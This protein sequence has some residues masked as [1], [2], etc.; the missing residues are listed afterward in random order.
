MAK[1]NKFPLTLEMMQD[2]QDIAD[3]ERAKRFKYPKMCS[4]CGSSNLLAI[5][6]HITPIM[7]TLYQGDWIYKDGYDGDSINDW[8]NAEYHCEDC[9]EDFEPSCAIDS[10][11]DGGADA[12]DGEI[13]DDDDEIFDDDDEIFDSPMEMPVDDGADAGTN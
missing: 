1:I 2:A 4:K 8:A 5:V 11:D 13:F 6:P 7:F 10:L 12:D 3:E 9:D